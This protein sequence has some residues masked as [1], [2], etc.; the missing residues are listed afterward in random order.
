RLPAFAALANALGAELAEPGSAVA[1]AA[2]TGA[3]AGGGSTETDGAALAAGAG[4][5]A[6]AEVSAALPAY[7]ATPTRIAPPASAPATPN[8]KRLHPPLFFLNGSSSSKSI[9]VSVTTAACVGA[10]GGRYGGTSS[11]FITVIGG[12]LSGCTRRTRSRRSFFSANGASAI[13]S[14]LTFGK[15]WS[16]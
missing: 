5:A 15:R 1:F 13:A 3:G 6:V 7:I 11:G 8:P 10:P 9:D 12:R 4:G 2:S 16:G 14:A